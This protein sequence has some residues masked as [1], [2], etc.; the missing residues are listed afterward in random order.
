MERTLCDWTLC[1]CLVK[2]GGAAIT[3]KDEFETINEAVLAKVVSQIKRLLTERPGYK[4]VIVHG[5]G[6]FGHFQA[7]KCGVNGG[8][9]D[10]DTVRKGFVDTRISVT[11]LNHSVVEALGKE[12]INAVG[13]SPCSFWRSETASADSVQILKS[14]VDNGFIP[15]VH[16]DA[17]I[18]P[19]KTKILSGDT[20]VHFLSTRVL[21]PRFVLFLVSTKYAWEKSKH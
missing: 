12:G 10:E 8:S 3:K 2:L 19:P 16:G 15:V 13:L 18:E 20:L 21:S 7:K 9:L 14:L 1:D 5:A 4:L 17:I 11:K 6:S